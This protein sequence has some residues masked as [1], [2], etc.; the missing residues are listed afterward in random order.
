MMTSHIYIG[1]RQTTR[2][3]LVRG[4]KSTPYTNKDVTDS[5]R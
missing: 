5:S 1:K 3:D 4:I 2:Q